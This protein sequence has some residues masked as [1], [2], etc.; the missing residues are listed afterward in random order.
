VG[1]GWGKVGVGLGKGLGRL[2]GVGKCVARAW[3]ARVVGR[4]GWRAEEYKRV[5]S[6]PEAQSATHHPRPIHVQAVHQQLVKQQVPW[7]RWHRE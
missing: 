4:A 5:N 1:N 3:G 6:G 2:D 7:S